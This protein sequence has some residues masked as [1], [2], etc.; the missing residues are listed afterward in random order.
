[1]RGLS[2]L[3]GSVSEMVYETHFEEK[4]FTFFNRCEIYG[5]SEW[6]GKPITCELHHINSDSTDNRI[7]N[8]QILCPNCHS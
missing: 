2:S 1:M 6:Q 7:E 8:L 5:I 3:Y 4:I